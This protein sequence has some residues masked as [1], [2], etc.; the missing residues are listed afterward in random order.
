[1]NEEYYLVTPQ[2]FA[3][4]HAQLDYPEGKRQRVHV[5]AGDNPGKTLCGR[6]NLSQ[7]E[8]GPIEDE[9]TNNPI[10]AWICKTC[11]KKYFARQQNPV[12]KRVRINLDIERVHKTAHHGAVLIADYL[13]R[14]G[15]T[16]V[17]VS[18]STWKGSRYY[19]INVDA[20]NIGQIEL[21]ATDIEII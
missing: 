21:L 16:G 9:N 6:D 8:A 17:I 12:E 19:V 18:S 13:S 7:W 2:T 3:W 14:R 10:N 1:M 20:P 11:A 4:I 15:N 5:V